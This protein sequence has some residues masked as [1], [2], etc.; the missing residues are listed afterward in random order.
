M[1]IALCLQFPLGLR[2]GVSVIVET[3]LRE[4]VARGHKI[5]LVSPDRVEDLRRLNIT[6]SIRQHIHF[7]EDKIGHVTA[8]KLAQRIAD[9]RVDVAH[10]HAGGAFVWGRLPFQSPISHLTRLGVPCLSTVHLVIALT[11]GYCGPQKPFWFKALLL[12]A[13]WSAKAQQLRHT[14]CE[15]TVSQ[16]DYQKLRRWYWPLKNRFVQIYHSRLSENAPAPREPRENI[17]LNVGHIAWRKGQAVLTEAFM[18]IADRHPDWTLQLAGSAQ[19]RSVVEQIRRL[20]KDHGLEGRI[21]MAGER[22]DALELMRR[23][24]IYVQ[25]SFWEALGLALQEAMHCGCACV[26]SRAG[27]IPELVRENETGLLVEPGSVAQLAAAL[28]QLIANERRREQLGRA[29]SAFVREQ[30]MTAD[31][32]A[33]RHL[34]LYETACRS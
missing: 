32:M 27:G 30:G 23:A 7:S 1:K 10:F 15:I 14:R 5:V 19:E 33:A 20:V 3:L 11:E 22:T 26:G 29:A 4:F 21:Q 16:H 2:G 34:E 25:P 28:E 13:V 17:I 12:P 24:A 6:T 31:R 18:R 9:A 8:K